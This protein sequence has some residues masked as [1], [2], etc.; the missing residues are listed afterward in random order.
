MKIT[1]IA[2]CTLI[3][4]P[5]AAGLA[6][7]QD[8]SKDR[9]EKATIAA[10]A[11]ERTIAVPPRPNPNPVPQRPKRERVRVQRQ[12]K[13]N[14]GA[15]H[16]AS[17]AVKPRPVVKALPPKQPWI[18]LNVTVSPFE[19]G[20]IR[21]YVRNCVDASKER[22]PTSVPPSLAK[23]ISGGGLPPDWQKRCVPGKV[24]PVEVH[25]RCEP[26]PEELLLKLPPPPPG[27]VLLAVNGTVVR[28]GYPTYEILDAFQVQ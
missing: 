25:Q 21:T 11:R 8:K 1:L 22:K 23:K 9:K 2:A 20:I 16:V 4:A 17:A 13:P 26:L 12:A 10:T 6:F 7:A 3:A 14:A 19:R 18:G 28:V 24:L 5:M 27:T 15:V